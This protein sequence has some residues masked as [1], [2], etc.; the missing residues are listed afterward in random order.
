MLA[1]G[2]LPCGFSGEGKGEGGFWVWC[3]DWGFVEGE[4]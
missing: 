3:W 1:L 4:L 2:R